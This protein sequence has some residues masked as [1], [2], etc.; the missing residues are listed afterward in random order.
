[1]VNVL[2]ELCPQP[3]RRPARPA[4]TINARMTLMRR[5]EPEYVA[6]GASKGS[7]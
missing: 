6:A 4:H 2:I 1:M 3:L 5:P 7:R